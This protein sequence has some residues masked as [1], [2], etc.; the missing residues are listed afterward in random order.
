VQYRQKVSAADQSQ[1]LLAQARALEAQAA[2]A[3]ELTS[4][5]RSLL[6]EAAQLRVRAL[7]GRAYPVFVCSECSR[8]TGW[9]GRSGRCDSCLRRAQTRAA[10]TD[11]RAGFVVLE[12]ARPQRART[13]TGR[14][15]VARVLAGPGRA[16]ADAWLARVDP[17]TTGPIDPEPGYGIEAAHRDEVAA[18][19]GSGMLVRFRTAT[20]RFDGHGW[21]ELETTRIAHHQLLVPSEHAAGL[22]AEQLVAAW[23][24]Y[25]AEVDGV[26]REAWS[27]ESARREADRVARAAQA[28]MLREQRGAVELLDENR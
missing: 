24:D 5:G 18:V 16:K 27:H 25:Q 26:N 11:P 19:D 14:G 17:N 3:G 12:D 15:L 8:V 13:H 10:Y 28:D 1:Q 9:L 4:H 2:R 21:D 20:H 6:A 23:L 7:A 22:P